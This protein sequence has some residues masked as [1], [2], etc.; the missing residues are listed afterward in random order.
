M[1]IMTTTAVYHNETMDKFAGNDSFRED[2]HYTSSEIA[3]LTIYSL[4]FVLGVL[5]NGVVIWVTGFKMKKTVNTVWYLNLPVADFL[6]SAFLP[7]TITEI[8]MDL[9]WPFGK[10]MCKTRSSALPSTGLRQVWSALVGSRVR[11]VG[12]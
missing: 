10:F 11:S 4:V 7:L 9:H 8:A 2:E 5:G 6:V 1:E 3:F 12:I